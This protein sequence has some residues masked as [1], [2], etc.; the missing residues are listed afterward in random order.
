VRQPAIEGRLLE[1]SLTMADETE[2]DPQAE[3]LPVTEEV[4]SEGGSYADAT[5]QVATETGNLPRADRSDADQPRA[6]REAGPVLRN[7]DAAD[8]GVRFPDDSRV[9]MP[10]DADSNS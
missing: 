10:D 4:G 2:R 9:R 7:P 1:E 8:D 3:P 6:G 5:A